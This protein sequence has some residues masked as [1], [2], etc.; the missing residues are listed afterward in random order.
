MKKIV[1]QD[2]CAPDS[3]ETFKEQMKN[4]IGIS[5]EEFQKNGLIVSNDYDYEIQYCGYSLR[6]S[7]DDQFW[8]L[9]DLRPTVIKT[10]NPIILVVRVNCRTSAANIQGISFALNEKLK[11]SYYV[12]VVPDQPDDTEVKFELLTI[13]DKVRELDLCELQEIVL[14]NCGE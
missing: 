7:A 14:K 13:D 1:E 10:P 3:M 4:K 6:C 12:L 8:K 9:Y 11:E 5:F 2:D